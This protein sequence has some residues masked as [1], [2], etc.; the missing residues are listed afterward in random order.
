MTRDE[1]GRELER[2]RADLRRHDHRYYVEAAPTISD[3]AYDRLYRSLQRLERDF[4]D[5]VTPDSTTQRVGGAPLKT[6]PVVR[7]R[8]PMLSMDNTYAPEELREFDARVRKSLGGAPVAYVVELKFDG[9]SVSLTYRH[10]RFV[11]GATRGD[12]AQG[13]DISAN[14]KTIRA[15]PLVLQA[16]PRVTLPA[17]MEV[18]GEVYLPRPAFEALNRAR[19]TAGE[20]LFVNPRNAAAGSLKLLDPRLVAARGLSLFLYGVAA[21]G[22]RAFATHHEVLEFLG[23][24][25]FRVNP[26]WARCATIDEVLRACYRWQ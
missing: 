14:L 7:H 18:R 20:P 12:G 4:P 13:D 11:R 5:L 8:V 6:F 3:P 17:T 2:L 9:V 16:P 22:G 15:L 23:A 25:G 19:A 1:A 21:V 10:G 24:V 26:H